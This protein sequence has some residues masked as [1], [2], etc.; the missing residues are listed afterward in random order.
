MIFAVR[1]NILP[2][3]F[4]FEWNGAQSL[5]CVRINSSLGFIGPLCQCHLLSV[6]GHET[7]SSS[8]C[9][10]GAPA[11]TFTHFAVYGHNGRFFL[12]VSTLMNL[13][14]RILTVRTLISSCR[15][16]S[17]AHRP[18]TFTRDKSFIFCDSIAA[19]QKT[20]WS[21]PIGF[22][23][24]GAIQHIKQD[25]VSLIFIFPVN[26]FTSVCKTAHS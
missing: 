15:L 4:S 13:P 6:N 20:K 19:N 25:L 3:R 22:L 18:A 9:V 17:I 5:T 16:T 7:T 2:L 11:L 10:P 21:G 14:V 26:V 12:F 23:V 24:G 1:F 8:C